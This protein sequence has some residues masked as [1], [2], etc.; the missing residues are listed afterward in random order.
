MGLTGARAGSP[1]RMFKF[2]TFEGGIRVPAFAL[3]PGYIQEG[4]S[5]NDFASV[6]DV[7]PTFLELA[8][9]KHPGNHYKGRDI[10]R[11]KGESMLS[12]LRGDA[13]STHQKDY[14]M[15]WELDGRRAIRQGDWKMV[16]E[17]AGIEREPAPNGINVEEWQLFDLSIDP[18]ELNNL[19]LKYPHKIKEMLVLW[20]QYV[21]D[22]GVI[23]TDNA[24]DY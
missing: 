11:M 1:F 23:I 17:P 5:S 24:G 9:V 8:R 2:F 4:V 20:E 12:M 10:H 14:V 3:Y 15:G 6:M 19:S 16:W 18:G 22:N 7:M 21:R 13:D